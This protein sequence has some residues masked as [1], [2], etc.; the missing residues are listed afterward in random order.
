MNS[1]GVDR[2][3]VVLLP[4]SRLVLTKRQRQNVSA[5]KE[6]S[7][8]I[9][10]PCLLVGG[11]AGAHVARARFARRCLPARMCNCANAYGITHMCLCVIFV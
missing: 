11:Q 10:K 9:V 3:M 6:L 2:V 1:E 8:L 4:R 5:N 7:H